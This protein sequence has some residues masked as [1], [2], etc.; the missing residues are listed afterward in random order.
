MGDGDGGWRMVDGGDDDEDVAN[1][2]LNVLTFVRCFD[3]RPCRD[4]DSTHVCI[5]PF[6]TR[7]V[8]GYR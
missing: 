7:N 6:V 8:S 5:C 3:Y 4:S 1:K 2:Y